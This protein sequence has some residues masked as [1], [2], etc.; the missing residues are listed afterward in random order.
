MLN[1][2]ELIE[3]ED[4]HEEDFFGDVYDLTVENNHSY[5]VNNDYIVHNCSDAA[6]GLGG[7]II[8]D[9]GCTCPGDIAKAFG[10]GCFIGE[11]PVIKADGTKK[12]IKN[13]EI[14]DEVYTHTFKKKKVKHKFEYDYIGKL[15]KINSIASTPNHKYYVLNKKY[16]NIVTKENINQY[17]EWVKAE[18]LDKENYFLL[19]LTQN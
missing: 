7:H 5:S 2:Y 14:G 6:H 12:E 11:T 1:K 16:R 17:A 4:I 19:K 8:S 15:V 13:I 3:I 18:D 9:G 10:A